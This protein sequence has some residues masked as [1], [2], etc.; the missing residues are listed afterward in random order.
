MKHQKL[1]LAIS[2]CLILFSGV[3]YSVLGGKPRRMQTIP[4]GIWGGQGIR[5]EITGH[6]ATVEYDCAN[7]TITGPF[8]LDKNHKFTLQ[9][10]HAAEHGGPI[11]EN[12]IRHNQPA[13]FN[14]W[15]DGRKMTLTVAL[16]DGKQDLGTFTLNHG[17]EGRLRK[18]R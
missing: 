1:K 14:G 9:G 6:S 10:T 13:Q 12:D 11:R 15:T 5:V 16:K 3:A 2:V 4:T 18:C 7:G 8:N 17:Q